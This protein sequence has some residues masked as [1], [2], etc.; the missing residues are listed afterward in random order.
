MISKKQDLARNR[1]WSKFKIKGLHVPVYGLTENEIKITQAIKNLQQMLL[2]DWNK[3]TCSLG[4][5]VGKQNKIKG[6]LDGKE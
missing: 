3:N 4:L 1:N 6:M 5:K 2:S